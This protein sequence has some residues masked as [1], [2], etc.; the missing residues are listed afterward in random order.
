[1][2]DNEKSYLIDQYLMDIKKYKRLTDD[3]QKKYSELYYETKDPAIKDILVKANLKYAYLIAKKYMGYGCELID[4]IQQANIG[5]I[6]GIENY[7]PYHDKKAKLSYYLYFWITCEIRRFISINSKSVSMSR[8]D[9]YLC[10]NILRKCII[11]MQEENKLPSVEELALDFHTSKEKI[12]SLLLSTD[13]ASL[14]K[15][16]ELDDNGDE[17]QD[18]IAADNC[19]DDSH[20]F[21]SFDGMDLFLLKETFKEI[22]ETLPDRNVEILKRRYG[23]F[24]YNKSETVRMIAKDYNLSPVRISQIEYAC[25]NKLRKM[26]NLNKLVDFVS[27]ANIEALLRSRYKKSR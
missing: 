18:F 27:E 23:L 14:N 9:Y 2:Q 17:L 3:E 6:E 5:V 19:Y 13:I 4:L 15:N 16:I 25:I 12:Q 22:F 10:N 26:D 20:N 7:N 21:K 1:M 8:K 11:S 24:P